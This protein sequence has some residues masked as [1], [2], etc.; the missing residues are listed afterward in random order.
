MPQKNSIAATKELHCSLSLNL[1][2]KGVPWST[3]V[4]LSPH[5]T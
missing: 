2:D 1:F 3:D 5:Y 4:I